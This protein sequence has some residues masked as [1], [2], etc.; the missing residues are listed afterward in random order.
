MDAFGGGRML[1]AV[2]RP[3]VCLRGAVSRVPERSFIRTRIVKSRRCVI[4]Y[5]LGDSSIRDQSH[6]VCAMDLTRQ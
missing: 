3:V 1:H 2:D 5:L 6:N 4:T